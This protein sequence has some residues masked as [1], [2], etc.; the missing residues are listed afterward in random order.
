MANLTLIDSL[1]ILFFLTSIIGYGWLTKS[2]PLKSSNISAGVYI[3]RTQWMETMIKREN[4]IVDL[5]ILSNL[6][7]GNAFFASTAIVITGA[8]AASLGAGTGL[9]KVLL[10]IPFAVKTTP[11]LL[12][13]KQ[14]FIMVIFLVAFFKFAWAYRLT[15]YTSI[16]MGALP[17]LTDSNEEEC[18]TYAARIA[19]LATLAGNQSNGGLHTYYYGIA[20]CAWFISPWL[21]MAA[22]SLIVLILYRR[23]YY[24]RGHAII[25]NKP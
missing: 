2:G 25:T 15:H 21:F 10:E 9:D 18:R 6:S 4:R 16:M 19:E 1:A 13:M 7:Q 3:E 22:T 14:I 8:M 23:E 17:H 5:M 11:E 20:A 24:S 12:H